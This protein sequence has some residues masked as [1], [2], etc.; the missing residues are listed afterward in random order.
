[1]HTSVVSLLKCSVELPACEG[2]ARPTALR[3]GGEK[4]EGKTLVLIVLKTPFLT[5]PRKRGKGSTSDGAV[6]KGTPFG[7]RT[8]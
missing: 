4:H 8:P 3:G 1:M 2:G 6:F 5:F 7:L